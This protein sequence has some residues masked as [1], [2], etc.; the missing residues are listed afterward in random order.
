M[1]ENEINPL[2]EPQGQFAQQVTDAF[3][4]FFYQLVYLL[5]ICPYGF[6]ERSAIRLSDMR[7]SNA[8]SVWSS[9]SRWPFLS[10]LKKII[11]D[12]CFDGTIFISYFAGAL[13]GVVSFFWLLADGVYFSGAFLTFI[14]ILIWSYYYPVYVS[15]IRDLCY[16]CLLPIRKFINWLDKPAQQLT[17][18]INDKRK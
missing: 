8:F 1:E 2:D 11:F 13:I 3:I 18:D 17:L 7:R 10:F 15:W 14:L 5:F 16:L 4:Y 12:F 9:D 6:W